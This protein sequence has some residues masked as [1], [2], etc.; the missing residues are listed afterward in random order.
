MADASWKDGN[1]QVAAHMIAN[2]YNKRVE[3]ANSL[4]MNQYAPVVFTHA[5]GDEN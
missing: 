2:L 3:T 4:I 1:F 5:G